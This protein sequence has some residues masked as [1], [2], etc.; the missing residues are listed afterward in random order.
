[1]KSGWLGYCQRKVV[2]STWQYTTH[3]FTFP[4]SSIHLATHTAR[5]NLWSLAVLKLVIP[6][7][8]VSWIPGARAGYIRSNLN[9]LA[10]SNC[11]FGKIAIHCNDTILILNRSVTIPK[12]CR[13]QYIFLSPFPIWPV[14]IY[15][16]IFHHSI[17]QTWSDK[18]RWHSS[19][20]GYFSCHL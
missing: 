8:V 6:A 4:T 11:K 16:A 20:I 2:Q 3:P 18:E 7:T 17:N 9:L 14:P 19:Y 1:M 13:T 12:W 10:K 15:V 5:K